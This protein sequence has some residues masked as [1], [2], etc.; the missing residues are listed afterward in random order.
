LVDDL[1]NMH[2]YEQTFLDYYKCYE[3]EI[4]YNIQRYVNHFMLGVK[5]RKE[6]REKISNTLK[7]HFKNKENHPFFNRKHKKETIEKMSKSKIG[8]YANE[9]NPNNKLSLNDCLVIK[10]RLLVKDKIKDIANDYNVTSETI[11][12][13]RRGINWSNKHLGGGYKDWIKEKM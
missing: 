6:S 11:S 4:G 12:H 13:I 9:S 10:E 3:P 7:E 5:L 2:I 1:E 8:R